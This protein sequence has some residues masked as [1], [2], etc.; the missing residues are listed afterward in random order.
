MIFNKFDKDQHPFLLGVAKIIGGDLLSKFLI[1][2][3]SHWIHVVF[4][5]SDTHI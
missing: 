1:A 4:K 2:F 3:Y 5:N